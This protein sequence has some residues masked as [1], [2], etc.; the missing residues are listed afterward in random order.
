VAAICVIST[1]RC[2]SPDSA[3]HRFSFTLILYAYTGFHL[4]QSRQALAAEAVTSAAEAVFF[5]VGSYQAAAAFA[6]SF[7]AWAAFFA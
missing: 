3:G 6:F 1:M 7:L 5:P 2:T 4:E